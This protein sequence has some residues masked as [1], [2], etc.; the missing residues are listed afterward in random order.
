MSL[1]LATYDISRDSSRQAV[2]R[3]LLRY[4][5]RLQESVFEIELEHE[6]V[7]DVK[8]E[9]GPWLATTDLFDLFPLDLRRP[10]SRISWQ[11]D[12]NPPDVEL[13]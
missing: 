7:I 5:R 2:A 13:Y 1:H 3:I 9:V 4:G 6:D 8:R 11:R 10:Q 12:P